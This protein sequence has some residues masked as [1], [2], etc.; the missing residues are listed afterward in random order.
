MC[1]G[2]GALASDAS[3]QYNEENR[4]DVV[5]RP[6]SEKR[7]EG[8]RWPVIRHCALKGSGVEGFSP[9]GPLITG[10]RRMTAAAPVTLSVHDA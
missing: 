8:N 7:S 6:E 9:G 1:C 2:V 10:R 4:R 5:C 3:N